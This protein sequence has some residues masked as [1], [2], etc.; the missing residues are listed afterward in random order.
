M[1]KSASP[2]SSLS[3]FA[4]R[5]ATTLSDTILVAFAITAL[6]T[7]P[8]AAPGFGALCSRL[9]MRARD[10]RVSLATSAITPP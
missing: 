4:A 2:S 7:C 10:S 5:S 8:P 9:L 1:I 3:S 6:G